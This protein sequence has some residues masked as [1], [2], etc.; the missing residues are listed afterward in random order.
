MP[1]T[2]HDGLFKTAFSQPDLA[3][4]ELELVLPP[5]LREQLDM[6][7]LAVCPGSFADGTSPELRADV[8]Y[9]VVTHTGEA[10]LVYVLLEHQSSFDPRMPLRLLGYML[11]V[12]E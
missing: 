5:A 9:R 2:P 6:S 7:T 8:L 12:W 3:R 1:P 4:S 10:A 11:R